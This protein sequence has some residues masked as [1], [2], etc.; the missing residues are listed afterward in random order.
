MDPANTHI[1]VGLAGNADNIAIVILITQRDI[2]I[3]EI[4]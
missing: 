3:L 2:A 4:L 1:G